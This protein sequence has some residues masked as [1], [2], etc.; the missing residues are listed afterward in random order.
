VIYIGSSNELRRRLK[1]HL[2]EA[3]NTCI[4]QNTTHYRIEYTAAYK[5]R[6]GELYEGYVR[7]HGKPPV[8]NDSTP[9]GN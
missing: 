9:S 6:E 1:E 8:C 4:R 7:M 3:S 2:N 5:I